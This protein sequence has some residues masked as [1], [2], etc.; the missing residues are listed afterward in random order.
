M[1]T[2]SKVKNHKLTKAE[3]KA[4]FLAVMKMMNAHEIKKNGF[5]GSGLRGDKG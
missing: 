3:K 5:L 4:W 2:K 1:E